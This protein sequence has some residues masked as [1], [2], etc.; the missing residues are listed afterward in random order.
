VVLAD[1]LVDR[2]GCRPEVQ[3]LIDYGSFP[4]ATLSMGKGVLEESR[5]GFLGVYSGRPSDPAVRDAIESAD[6]V[7]TVGVIFA[8]VLTAGFTQRIDPERLIDIR[9]FWRHRRPP[10][11][12]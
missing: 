1:F 5:A 12:P 6:I 4:Y 9:P 8:D 3:R 7:I 11:F 2:F 10:T